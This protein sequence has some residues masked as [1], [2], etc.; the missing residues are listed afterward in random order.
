MLFYAHT[1]TYSSG[2]TYE[3]QKTKVNSEK[4]C[5]RLLIIGLIVPLRLWTIISFLLTE[6]NCSVFSSFVDQHM[7]NVDSFLTT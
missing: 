4:V 2:Y 7:E 3:K 6:S 5:L 1:H